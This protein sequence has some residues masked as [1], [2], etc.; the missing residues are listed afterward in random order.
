[1]IPDFFKIFK[2]ITNPMCKIEKN[3]YCKQLQRV[4][5]FLFLHHHL[6]YAQS[7]RLLENL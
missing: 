5:D 6:F 3:E 7:H 4:L 2:K 1:M